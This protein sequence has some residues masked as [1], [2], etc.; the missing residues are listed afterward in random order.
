MGNEITTEEMAALTGLSVILIDIKRRQ[1]EADKQYSEARKQLFAIIDRLAGPDS[2][3]T[4]EV[5]TTGR[6]IGR[7]LVYGSPSMDAD[8]LRAEIGDEKF[9]KVTTK[10]VT[11]AIDYA[12]M[13]EAILAE[14][15]TR[16]QIEK[17]VIPGRVTQRFLHTKIGS[18]EDQDTETSRPKTEVE[19]LLEF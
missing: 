17:A 10:T 15:V 19:G 13:R 6:R 9:E 16:S 5:P 2:K 8:A 12:A 11:F 1:D 4:V 7:T 14:E 3:L 18:R